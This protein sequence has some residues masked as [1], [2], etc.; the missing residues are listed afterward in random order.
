MIAVTVNISF[1][2]DIDTIIYDYI[3]INISSL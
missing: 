2:I 1:L 3:N